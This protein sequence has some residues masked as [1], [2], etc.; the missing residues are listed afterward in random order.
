MSTPVG[1]RSADARRY[2]SGRATPAGTA[3]AAD[4]AGAEGQ[5]AGPTAHAPG[6]SGTSHE[7]A[8]PAAVCGVRTP[9]VSLRQHL[10][11]PQ[12]AGVRPAEQQQPPRHTGYPQSTAEAHAGPG[13]ACAQPPAGGTQAAQPFRL[14]WVAELEDLRASTG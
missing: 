4:S 6:A 10:Q 7:P 2:M 12:L 11:P 9:V 5:A 13:P 8:L 1:F 3:G 14:L